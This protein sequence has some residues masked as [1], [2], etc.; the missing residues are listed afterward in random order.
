MSIAPS[1]PNARSMSGSDWLLLRRD[2]VLQLD[3]R[4][5][6]ETDDKALIYMTYRGLRHGPADVIAKLGRGEAVDPSLYYFRATPYFETAAE[7]YAWMNGICCIATGSRAASGPTYHV[8]Q[9][10]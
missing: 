4:L 7:K 8:F 1:L 3:V 6:L 9:V 10:L 2:G 5:M